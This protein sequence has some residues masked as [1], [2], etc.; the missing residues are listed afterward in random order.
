[1]RTGDHSGGSLRQQA[2]RKA[3]ESRLTEDPE[4]TSDATVAPHS[5]SD[6]LKQTN[7]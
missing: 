1:M 7:M 5:V 2:I 3:E 4:T 6:G